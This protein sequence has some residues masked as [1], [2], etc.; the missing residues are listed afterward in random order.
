MQQVPPYMVNAYGQPLKMCI[1]FG[2]V[3]PRRG[4]TLGYKKCSKDQDQDSKCPPLNTIMRKT[5]REGG[6]IK[7]WRKWCDERKVNRR[8][9]S[10]MSPDDQ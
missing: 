5:E 4:R 1:G 3:H 2:T 6:V 9:A 10:N 7:L 8:A